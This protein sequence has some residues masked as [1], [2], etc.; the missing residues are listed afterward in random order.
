MADFAHR[1]ALVTTRR[2]AGKTS[3]YTVP[4]SFESM[5]AIGRMRGEPPGDPFDQAR[6]PVVARGGTAS[7]RYR[8]HTR[9]LELHPLIK[10]LSKATKRLTFALV[11]RCLD[12]GDFAAFSIEKGRL[13]GKW[14]GDAWRTSFWEAAARE[15][16][17]PLDEAYDDP[18]AEWTA[19]SR[20]TDAAVRIATGTGRR[21][22]W[23]GRTYRVLEDEQALAISQ[24]AMEMKKMADRERFDS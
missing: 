21:Y 20:M 4:F 10:R 18:V 1:V 16:K 3:H 12:D 2:V 8:L 17:I 15:R 19:E 11:T 6:W 23:H 7:V 22:S 5:F 13:R 9:S 14:L 24:L